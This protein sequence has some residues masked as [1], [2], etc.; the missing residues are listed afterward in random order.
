MAVGD[1]SV[2]AC[3]SYPRI[4]LLSQEHVFSK[5]L[6]CR[7]QI[8]HRWFVIKKCVK[9][10]FKKGY[11]FPSFIIR[12]AKIKVLF[13]FSHFVK[14]LFCIFY[15]CILGQKNWLPHFLLWKYKGK[16]DVWSKGKDDVLSTRL[17]NLKTCLRFPCLGLN[18]IID[19]IKL[20]VLLWC[21]NNI[22]MY[23]V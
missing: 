10:W 15:C 1:F 8:A 4:K 14:L 19:S 17:N 20:T 2:S 3:L 16:D 12:Q 22:N 13:S 5:Y 9:N 7:R 11:Y 18:T 6:E 23:V 21:K